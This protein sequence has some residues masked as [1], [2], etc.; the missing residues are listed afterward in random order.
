MGVTFFK[1]NENK[2][3]F[4]RV[5]LM[6]R[7][8]KK[9]EFILNES[10][11]KA[12]GRK[13]VDDK[14]IGID[15]KFIYAKKSWVEHKRNWNQF[16]QYAEENGVKD[17]RK[18][19]T[20]LVHNY[21]KDLASQGYAKKT[22]ESRI[23]AVNKI[24]VASGRWD[25]E[26]RVILT[27]IE[28]LDIKKL[29]TNVYKDLTANE[30]IQRNETTYQNH[31]DLFDTIQSFG[32]RRKEVI[33]LNKNS[34]LVDKNGKMYIQTIGKGG[35]Y[36]ISESADEKSNELMKKLYG[37]LARPLE[38]ANQEVLERSIR[39]EGKRLRIKG[40]NCHNFG[41]HIHR[42]EYAQRL[43]RA[44]IGAE[45]REIQR[46]YKGYS[47]LKTKELTK[48]QLDRIEIKIG[49]FKGSASSFLEVSR[50]LGHNRLD[51]LLKYL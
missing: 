8:Q 19:N 45:N 16:S 50:N 21:V 9:G 24:M 11:K 27:K 3:D 39:D 51:V 7:L 1:E 25:F 23:G 37:N 46:E 20:E 5:F 18:I 22:I 43:L 40:A 38:T 36:R 32:L 13:R 42:A 26:N 17:L 29:K 4:G 28:D 31:K 44:K 33:E 35:K 15:N 12:R 10:Y 2:E 48:E 34:F 6:G 41:L 14:K 49:T 30:W 47:H